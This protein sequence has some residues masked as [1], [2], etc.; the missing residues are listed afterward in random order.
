MCIAKMFR[1]PLNNQDRYVVSCPT[2]FL[3]EINRAE[4]PFSGCFHGQ[5]IY[6]L[7][8]TQPLVINTISVLM[9]PHTIRL[10]F[11]RRPYRRKLPCGKEICRGYQSQYGET[12]DV[13]PSE[14]DSML[15]I[16]GGV[17]NNY[18][19]IWYEH[20]GLYRNGVISLPTKKSLLRAEVHFRNYTADMEF[21]WSGKR[22]SNIEDTIF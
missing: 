12:G 18:R 17:I 11:S 6:T 1:V 13:H 22:S 14:K 7:L 9:I 2:I 20:G 3:S 10:Y 16:D 8:L 21:Y 15:L 5:N 19:W 4:F